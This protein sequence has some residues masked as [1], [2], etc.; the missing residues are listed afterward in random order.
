MARRLD[1][2]FAA[3]VSAALRLYARSEEFDFQAILDDIEEYPDDPE[4]SNIITEMRE[5]FDWS[6]G[7]CGRFY[8]TLKRI[9][10]DR[11][12]SAAGAGGRRSSSI[13]HILSFTNAYRQRVQAVGLSAADMN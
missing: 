6:R 1:K 11:K 13:V 9:L 8:R 7:D 10:L 4:D 12:Q 2:I 3:E 5:R